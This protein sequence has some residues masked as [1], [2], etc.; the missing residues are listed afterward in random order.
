VQ[1]GLAEVVF[2]HDMSGLYTEA[3]VVLR[4][5]SNGHLSMM[6]MVMVMVMVMMMMM[7]VVMTPTAAP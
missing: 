1:T 3:P 2:Y 4:P 7:M 5:S 6:V